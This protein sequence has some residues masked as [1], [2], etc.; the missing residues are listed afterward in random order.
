MKV[1]GE[2]VLVAVADIMSTVMKMVQ[3]INNQNR[4]DNYIT[5]IFI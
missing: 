4:S 1:L 5:S 3:D 2:D